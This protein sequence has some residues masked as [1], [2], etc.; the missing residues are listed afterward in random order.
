MTLS[1]RF[2][3]ARLAGAALDVTRKEPIPADSPLVGCPNLIITPHIAGS[4]DDV[5]A[6]GTH[7]VI[8]SLR[9]YLDGSRLPY[10]V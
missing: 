6:C 10:A 4:A 8:E 3:L 9:A 2:G 7:M 5:Q 1:I